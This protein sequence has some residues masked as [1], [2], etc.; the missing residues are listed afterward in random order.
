MECKKTTDW[1]FFLDEKPG[2]ISGVPLKELKEKDVVEAFKH[3]K[4]NCI[5]EKM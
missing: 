3:W 5:T 2:L 1:N 4:N